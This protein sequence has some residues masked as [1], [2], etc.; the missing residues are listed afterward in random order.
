MDIEGHEKAVFA[1]P[2]WLAS[3]DTLALERYGFDYVHVDQAGK[4]VGIQSSMFLY[5]S[6]TGARSRLEG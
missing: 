6:C 2:E 1:E 4:P 5:A 3:V